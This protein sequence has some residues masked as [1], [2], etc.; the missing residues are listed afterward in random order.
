[1]TSERSWSKSRVN[2]NIGSAV[3]SSKIPA[4]KRLIRE[5]KDE[6]EYLKT[7]NQ[8]IRKSVKY[9]KLSEL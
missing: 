7:E 6:V 2:S 4:M 5:S 3:E 8:K 9:T 1:M